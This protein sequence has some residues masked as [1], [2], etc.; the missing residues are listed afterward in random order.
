MRYHLFKSRHIAT[1]VFTVPWRW[2]AYG[3]A[4][5]MSRKWPFCRLVD[6]L[7]NETLMEWI[8]TE[9]AIDLNKISSA[10]C[11]VKIES[12]GS[13]HVFHYGSVAYGKGKE[14]KGAHRPLT[15]IDNATAA[16]ATPHI[17]NAIKEAELGR[18]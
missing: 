14:P 7:E 12:N 15:I 11:V 9:K 1:P 6:S 10:I 17:K 16:I 5:I 3:V 13:R 18:N 4:N 2:L 8:T